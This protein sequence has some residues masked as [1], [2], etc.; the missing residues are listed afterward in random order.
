[1]EDWVNLISTVGFPIVAV[2]ACAFFI[3]K[4]W[5]N[6]QA[7]SERREERD[8]ETITRLSGILSENSKAL[9]KNSEV[10]EKISDKIDSIDEKVEE[11]KQDVNEIK[12]RQSQSNKGE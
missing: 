7:Q 12:I 9:L 3:F 2:M 5:Q 8:R 6:E 11:V 4:V 10:M 1:M